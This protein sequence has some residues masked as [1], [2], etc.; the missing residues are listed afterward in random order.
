MNRTLLAAVAAAAMTG[1]LVS[2]A[3]AAG[4]D[5]DRDGMPNAWEVRNHL[6]PRSAADARKDPDKDVLSNL[7]EYKLGTLPRKGD[8]DRDGTKDAGED[9]DRDGTHTG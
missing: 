9:R 7:W 5:S 6:N 3:A 1:A 4:R 2:P 8:S